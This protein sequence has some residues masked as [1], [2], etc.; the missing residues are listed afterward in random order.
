[1]KKEYWINVKH[2]DKRLFFFK[3]VKFCHR[4]GTN[5]VSCSTFRVP[6]ARLAAARAALEFPGKNV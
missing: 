2:V 1:M 5:Y 4:L 6:I 3:R